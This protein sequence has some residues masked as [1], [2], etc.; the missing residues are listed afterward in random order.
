MEML[1]QRFLR[2]G[3]VYAQGTVY[4]SIFK[5]YMS[6]IRLKYR[7]LTLDVVDSERFWWS[8]KAR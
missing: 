8:L 3:E 4:L 6:T 1:Q 7:V 2:E 5:T